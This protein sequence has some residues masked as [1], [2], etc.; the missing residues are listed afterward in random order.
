MNIF[1]NVGTRGGTKNQGSQRSP[2]RPNPTPAPMLTNA[3]EQLREAVEAMMNEG[4]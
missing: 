1:A 3:L 2:A 4:K